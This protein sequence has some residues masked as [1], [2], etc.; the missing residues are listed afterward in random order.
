MWVPQLVVMVLLAG[1]F[2]LFY[3]KRSSAKAAGFGSVQPGLDALRASFM[4][5]RAPGEQEP[6]CVVALHFS[7]LK[8]EQVTVGVTD[9]RILVIKGAGAMH[10]FPY[11]SEG[12]HLPEAQKQQQQRGF[13][14][15]KHGT[16]KD[17]SNAYCPTVKNH[18]PFSG[19]EWRM[20]PTI[21]G[22]PEQKANLKAFSDR[23][24]FRWFYD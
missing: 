3:V 5:T 23:F 7:M 11:D 16:L 22:F 14:N 15:W 6:L 4:Q 8:A 18:P 20:Y 2:A 17:G 10:A 19:E 21:E 24:Y 13:F 1:A 12:E 9:R